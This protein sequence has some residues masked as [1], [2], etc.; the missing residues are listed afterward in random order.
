MSARAEYIVRQQGC[1]SK[2]G[3]PFLNIVFWHF[4]GPAIAATRLCAAEIQLMSQSEMNES[5]RGAEMMRSAT[6]GFMHCMLHMQKD[7]LAAVSP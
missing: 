5:L 1:S 7:R 3:E 2:F 4:L 6:S